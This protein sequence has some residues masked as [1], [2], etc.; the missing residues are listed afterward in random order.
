[1]TARPLRF[2][3]F[4]IK[5]W[6][7]RSILLVASSVLS[8]LLPHIELTIVPYAFTLLSLHC[9]HRI[10]W[11]PSAAIQHSVRDANSATASSCGGRVISYTCIATHRIHWGITDDI[12]TQGLDRTGPQGQGGLGCDVRAGQRGRAG[13]REQCSS[14][15]LWKTCSVP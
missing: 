14:W 7:S 8:N 4:Q 6:A 11:L 10:T 2:T 5:F 15:S 12:N 13:A 9:D 3:A 1:M